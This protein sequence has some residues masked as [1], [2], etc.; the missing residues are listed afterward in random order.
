MNY[1]HV[2]SDQ[3][4][5][6]FG[7]EQYGD[8]DEYILNKNSPEKKIV[9]QDGLEYYTVYFRT[10][11]TVEDCHKL[12]GIQFKNVKFHGIF[13]SDLINWLLSRVRG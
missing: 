1:L 9:V 5:T 2:Y 11:Q 8:V 13:H 4:S 12:S 10:I 3:K 6:C 7:F